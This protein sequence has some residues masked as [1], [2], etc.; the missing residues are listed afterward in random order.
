MTS[1][2]KAVRNMRG[3]SGSWKSWALDRRGE[4]AGRD[5]GRTDSCFSINKC[6]LSA[7]KVPA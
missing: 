5:E 4:G 7:H 1:K 6:L 2:D 3:C